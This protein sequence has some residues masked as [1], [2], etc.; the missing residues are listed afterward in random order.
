MT[1]QRDSANPR[2]SIRYE[3]DVTGATTH[4]HV[5]TRHAAAE[6]L[7]MRTFPLVLRAADAI[8]IWKLRCGKY[9]GSLKPA[10]T[11]PPP[12]AGS[13]GPVGDDGTHSNDAMAGVVPT[14]RRELR[15][16][17]RAFVTRLRP[18]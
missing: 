16:L 1:G 11:P 14:S 3:R 17:Q 6:D 12:R 10:R 13:T 5:R 2:A 8:S 4:R 9:A 18:P 15:I 7:A